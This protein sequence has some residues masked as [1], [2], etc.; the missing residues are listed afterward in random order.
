MRNRWQRWGVAIVAMAFL[1]VGVLLFVNFSK[2]EGVVKT[3]TP[4]VS[5]ALDTTLAASD[6]PGQAPHAAGG[7]SS[8]PPVVIRSPEESQRLRRRHEEALQ[9]LGLPVPTTP[10]K[11]RTPLAKENLQAPPGQKHLLLVKFRDD[12][13]ARSGADGRL[14]ISANTAQPE[15][16]GVIEEYGLR[17]TPSQT[18]STED[19]V[20]LE[21]RALANTQTEPAD[22]SGMLIAQVAKQ[23]PS[24]VWEAAQ[25]MQKLDAV[26]F[27]SLSSLDSPPP[28][29]L[30]YDIAPPSASLSTN[31][32]YRTTNGIN[33]DE[34]WS[35]YGARGQ[36]VQVINCEY[37]YNAAHEDL[38]QIVSQQP[39]VT[40]LYTNFGDDHGTSVLGILAAAENN[41]GM[42]GTLPEANVRFYPE[43]SKINGQ[44]QYRPATI[45]AALA[46]SAPGD[47]VLLE[48]QTRGYGGT[49]K[50]TRYVPAEY[51]QAVWTAVKTG[52]DAGVHV[53]AAAGNGGEDLDSDA[54]APYRARGDSGA[55]IVGASVGTGEQARSRASFSTYGARVNLQGWGDWS[56]ATL[57]E[58]S[59]KYGDDHNQAYT[60]KFSGTSSASPIVTSAVGAVESIARP[61]LG[62]P[63]TP[64]EMRQLLINTGK[65]QTGD[66]TKH[67]GSLP[68]VPVAL[69]NLLAGFPTIT[70]MSPD[71][72][73]I[74]TTV[75]F[76]GTGFTGTTAVSFGSVAAPGFVVVNDTTLHV[77]LP[78]GAQS[79]RILVTTSAGTAVSVE[80]FRVI[81]GEDT[82]QGRATPSALTGFVSQQGSI[83]AAQTFTVRGDNLTAGFLI[84][85]PAGYEVSLDGTNY[86][87]ITNVFAVAPEDTASNYSGGWTNGSNAGLGFEAWQITTHSGTNY[88]ATNLIANPS[89]AGITDFGIEAFA[90]V[91]QSTNS[92]AM[93]ETDRSLAG[94][95]KVGDELKFQWAVNFDAA[96]PTGSKG[97]VLYSGATEL[98]RVDQSGTPG[99]I[100]FAHSGHSIDI[101]ISNGTAPITWSF[102]RTGTNSLQVAATGRDG[103][104]NIVF[105]NSIVIPG[106]PDAVRW[107]ASRLPSDPAEDAAKHQPYFNNLH[108][109]PGILGGGSVPPTLV[110]VRLANTAPSGNVGGNIEISSVGTPLQ[111]VGASGLVVPHP[112]GYDAWAMGYG[113]DPL[114][115]GAWDQDP[116]KDQINNLTE[117]AFGSDPTK[118][119]SVLTGWQPTQEGY[120]LTFLARTNGI[121]Y[122][123][124]TRADLAS[125]L[126]LNAELTPTE[127]PDQ[128]DVPSG[129]HRLESAVPTASRAFYRVLSTLP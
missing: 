110:H 23:D 13:L 25:A 58:G 98:L 129:Y 17:F 100:L 96:S 108:I 84:T 46:A 55:L 7:S 90:L 32:G 9:S 47:V 123:I 76:T 86:A 105:S 19:V 66:I 49:D 1:I 8:V 52:T 3:M 101:G 124:Q 115:D 31:Q 127:S 111:F 94:P 125:G 56:V 50:D 57:G 61:A 63:L 113:L 97:F 87:G 109:A 18:A 89:T 126:W 36:G 4:P 2:T 41:Y 60:F 114:S 22:L 42:T 71:K 102:T 68:D 92:P 45:T 99:A 82:P 35:T 128:T 48:M 24:G 72:G 10:L 54:Y 80:K 6:K 59:V 75:T 73:S 67:I 77:P 51:E 79:E 40:K 64:S 91:A 104:T 122:K 39:W 118:S 107:Y 69:A 26:E 37:N 53:V 11:P 34:A 29:P 21:A 70:A 16:Q 62:R 78:A 27:V 74:S 44:T 38:R 103:S 117:F 112:V 121:V 65:P 93:V 119:T 30:P 15:L 83:S 85:A 116:D 20:R 120:R 12:L 14:V 88:F 33:I 28:P 106:A 81:A 95:L 43:Y 5:A